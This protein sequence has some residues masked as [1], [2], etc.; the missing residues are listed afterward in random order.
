MFEKIMEF[1][2]ENSMNVT[3]PRNTYES[4]NVVSCKEMEDFLRELLHEGE[5]GDR[6]F[7]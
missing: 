7:W 1:M 5:T 4:I 3:N 2:L 6:F